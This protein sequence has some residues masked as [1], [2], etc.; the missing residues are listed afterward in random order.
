MVAAAENP[1]LI[2]N[3]QSNAPE[4]PLCRRSIRMKADCEEVVN[5]FQEKCLHIPLN[6][7][8]NF[9]WFFVIQGKANKFNERHHPRRQCIHA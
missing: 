1:A 6:Y 4:N 2:L 7:E 3:I 5:S 8:K 9:H